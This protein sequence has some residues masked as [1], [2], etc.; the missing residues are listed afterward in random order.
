[1]ILENI[2]LA[3]QALRSNKMRSLLTMLGIIIGISAVIAIVDVGSAVEKTVNENMSS[4][5]ASNIYASVS[6]R[7]EGNENRMFMMGGGPGGGGNGG[8]RGSRLSGKTPTSS[9]LITDKMVENIKEEFKDEIDGVSISLSGGQGKGQDE[10]LYANVNIMGVNEDYFISEN[11]TLLYGRYI[12]N[13]DVENYSNSAVVSD[14]FVE[15]LF[16]GDELEKALGKQIKIFKERKIDIYTIVGIYEYEQMSFGGMQ[17]S[18]KEVT[19]SLYIPLSIEKQNLVEKNYTYI[20][21]ITKTETSVENLTD[22]LSA[23]FNRLYANNENWEVSVDNMSAMLEEI[24]D[25]LDTVTT[26]IAIIAAISLLVGGIGIMNIMLVSVTE[27]TREIGTR[28]AMGAKTF[29]I[30]MQ[31]LIESVIVSLVGGIIGIIL[32]TL[33]GIL[34]A[35]LMGTSVAISIPIMFLSFGFSMLIGMFFGIYPA[36]KAAKLD[37]IEALRYE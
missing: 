16:P 7:S 19:T 17:V 15:N 27:R 34:L 20:T 6:E 29:H 13:E 26:A 14:K 22:K 12:N 18:D 28:K 8:G 25:T 31:F 36:S 1:M 33:L 30:Q 5:G 24:S 37:P 21:I 11:M 32:G 9:D 35:T 2:L 10:D 3:L 4:F 23:Y